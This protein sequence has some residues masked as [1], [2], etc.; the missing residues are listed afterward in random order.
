MLLYVG[1]KGIDRMRYG[2]VI[3]EGGGLV[4]VVRWYEEMPMV[5]MDWYVW[6]VVRTAER[7]GG[8]GKAWN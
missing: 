4:V 7:Q 1:Y 5:G 2:Q 3:V 8:S 6:L